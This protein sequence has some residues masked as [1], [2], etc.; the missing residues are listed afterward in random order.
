MSYV[1]SRLFVPCENSPIMS[2]QK[3]KR[4]KS[5]YKN[6]NLSS[7]FTVQLQ[8]DFLTFSFFS[9][10]LH[11]QGVKVMSPYH[12]VSHMQNKKGKSAEER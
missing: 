5:N 3:N 12:T 11:H 9:W 4:T 1:F 10:A 7:V 8:C 2:N 6:A